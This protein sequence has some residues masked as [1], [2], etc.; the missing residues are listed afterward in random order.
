M[1][2]I[3]GLAVVAFA[4]P[5]SAQIA[6][7]PSLKVYPYESNVWYD[8]AF[9]GSGWTVSWISV[10]GIPSGRLGSFGFYTYDA[11]G[12]A[13]WLSFQ[14]PYQ[15][16]AVS[17]LVQGAITGSMTGE[18]LEFRGGPTPTGPATPAASSVSPL[19][20]ATLRWL[21]PTV[22]EA[23]Y[24]GVVRRLVPAEFAVGLASE[25]SILEGRWAGRLRGATSPPG[26]FD[27]CVFRLVRRSAP[28][29][30]W[31]VDN[32]FGEVREVPR[33]DSVWFEP[34][35]ESGNN[36]L[37]SRDQ[38]WELRPS[39]GEVRVW[40]LSIGSMLP[41]LSGYTITGGALRYAY[42]QTAQRMVMFFG[43]NRVGGDLVF[44]EGE[45]TKLP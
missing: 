7:Q 23:S 26:L 19:G 1:A 43:E 27:E 30:R 33:T 15:Q 31:V 9:A 24:A 21:S 3:G 36:G 2:V 45:F 16:S 18:L 29:Q 10:P 38:F 40:S 41:D 34:I 44:A 6:M 42:I 35:P 8:P 4:G 17:Q 39:T 13:T 14:H 37:C 22:I 5:A 25:T 11:T 28:G 32:R 12:R 20:T